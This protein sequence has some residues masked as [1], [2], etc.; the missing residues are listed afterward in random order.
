M[1]NPNPHLYRQGIKAPVPALLCRRKPDRLPPLLLGIS[2]P[3]ALHFFGLP[4][5]DRGAPLHFGPT[6][7]PPAR[8]P[9]RIAFLSETPSSQPDADGLTSCRAHCGCTGGSKRHREWRP[10]GIRRALSRKA[11]RRRQTVWAPTGRSE[12]GIERAR[13]YRDFYHSAERRS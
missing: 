10:F 3:S 5:T 6:R 4:F 7:A 1:G 2:T 13:A 12:A 11:N 9:G 8:R